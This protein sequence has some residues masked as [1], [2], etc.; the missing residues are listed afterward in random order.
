M[1]GGSFTIGSL[2]TNSIRYPSGKYMVFNVSSGERK[3]TT[4]SLTISGFWYVL[5]GII[6]FLLQLV[7]KIATRRVDKKVKEKKVFENLMESSN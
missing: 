4:G 2:A 6:S 7:R 5:P 1:V 3:S